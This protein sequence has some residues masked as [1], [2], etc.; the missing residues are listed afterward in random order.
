MNRGIILALCAYIF[1]GIHPI[2]WKLLQNVP[3]VEIVAHRIIWSLLFFISIIFF[4]KQWNEL[5]KKIIGYDKKIILFLPAFLIGSNWGVYIWAVNTGFIIETSLGYFIS[6]LLSVFL[7]VIFLNEKLR[8]IQWIAVI[9]A[10]TGVLVMTIIYGQFPWISIYLAG[11]W[12]LYG[13]LRKKSPLGPVEGLCLETATLS[14]F[15][16][17]YLFIIIKPGIGYIFS[18]LSSSLLLIGCGIISGLPLIIFITGARLIK[19]SLIGILQYIYPT[20]IFLIGYFIYNEVL[21]SAKIAGFIF[22]WVAIIIYIIGESYNLKRKNNLKLNP[23][24]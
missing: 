3:A 10:C 23:K 2:Y 21:N 9:I 24:A 16:V 8:R 17:F 1:W 13:M 12:S 5:I 4:K 18:E 6:P 11:S 22:I 15:A 7:G 20:M 19:L 14:V